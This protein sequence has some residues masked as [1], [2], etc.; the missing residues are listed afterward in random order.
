MSYGN[1]AKRMKSEIYSSSQ[2]SSAG[3]TINKD[4]KS[5]LR[6]QSSLYISFR[7]VRAYKCILTIIAKHQYVYKRLNAFSCISLRVFHTTRTLFYESG[8]QTRLCW[9]VSVSVGAA[10][11]SYECV[12]YPLREEAG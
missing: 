11:S 2:V 12:D 3:G 8:V 5:T 6:V 10:A 9:F 1:Q 4:V 7:R